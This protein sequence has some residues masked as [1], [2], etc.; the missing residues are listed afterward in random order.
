MLHGSLLL[1]IRCIDRLQQDWCQNGADH[2]QKDDSCE[3]FAVDDPCFESSLCNDQGHLAACH[4][5]DP[6]LE[7]V[8]IVK[9]QHLR[10]K[11]AAD[12]FAQQ[13]N[14]YKGGG[15]GQDGHV[16]GSEVCLQ[17]YTQHRP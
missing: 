7:A 10:N 14:R 3:I 11:A 2:D 1:F 5:A 4:H 16:D 15:E 8:R 13:P 17:S 9:A 12:H 6:D